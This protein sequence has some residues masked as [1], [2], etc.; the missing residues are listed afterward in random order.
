MLSLIAKVIAAFIAAL[1]AGWQRDRE[2]KHRAAAEA[3]RKGLED[4]NARARRADAAARDVRGG[5]DILRD[6]GFRRD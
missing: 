6:D 1:F 5:P 4:I 2:L 3:Q